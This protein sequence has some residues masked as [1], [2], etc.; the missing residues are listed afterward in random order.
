[1]AVDF[2]E[3]RKQGYSEWV[4]AAEKALKGK[5][6]DSLIW[7]VDD[8]INMDPIHTADQPR[9]AGNT[10]ISREDNRWLIG[11]SFDGSSAPTANDLLLKA[12]QGGLDSPLLFDVRNFEACL[13]QVRLD[14]LFPIF[15]DSEWISYRKYLRF[16]GFDPK[17]LSGGFIIYEAGYGDLDLYDVMQPLLEICIVLP[18][19]YHTTMTISI[20]SFDIGES[21]GRSLDNLSGVIYQMLYQGINPRIICEVECDGDFVKNV[22]TIRALRKQVHLICK[23]YGIENDSVMIDAYAYESAQD[24]QL[25]MIG[26]TAKAVSAVSAGVDRLTIACESMNVQLDEETNR[27][28]ARNVHHLMMM[29]SGLDKI[30]DPLC[31]SYTIETLTEKIAERSWGEFQR[32]NK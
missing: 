20:D 2:S 28:M 3:F 32:L 22:A 21:M 23:S 18:R 14:F 30:A 11:E 13:N 26:A 1:M 16:S 12:L 19:F 17:K 31:G 25:A 8:A 5:P 15:R 10:S 4:K 7:K 6:L 29:E 9:P 24:A 27:R